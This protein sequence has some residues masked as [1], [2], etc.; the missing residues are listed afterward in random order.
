MPT[1]MKTYKDFC[2]QLASR[3]QEGLVVENT[4]TNAFLDAMLAWLKDTN[5]G[6]NFFEG[7]S[8]EYILWSD[9][10]ALIQASSIYE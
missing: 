5:G 8:E 3:D 4:E 2:N 1:K 9:L 10:W 6:D 7:N